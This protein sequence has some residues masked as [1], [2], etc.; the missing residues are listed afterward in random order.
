M[1]LSICAGAQ[2]VGALR[3]APD[4]PDT[5]FD[6]SCRLE[7]GLW[8]LYAEGT[9]GR[10]LLGVVEG[11]TPVALCRRFSERLTQPLGTI[12]RAAAERS[13]DRPTPWRP[14]RELTLP[15]GFSFP[16]TALGRR[17]GARLLVALPYEEG[18]PFPRTDLFCFARIC[19]MQ[20]GQWAVFAFDSSGC[21]V[22]GRQTG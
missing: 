1:E 18:R 2:S 13:A 19:R 14:L 5:C 4:G 15:K 10:L 9:G 17:A 3:I 12:V 16:E 21:P 7:P 6:I 11:G 22:M 20:R 8:R